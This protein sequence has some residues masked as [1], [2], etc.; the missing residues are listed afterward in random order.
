MGEMFQGAPVR[1]HD[2]ATD[3]EPKSSPGGLRRRK[4]IEHTARNLAVNP[5]AVVT[6][7]DFNLALGNAP[8]AHDNFLGVQLCECKCFKRITNEIENDLLD[9]RAI[10]RDLREVR[11]ELRSIRHSVSLRIALNE[12]RQLGDDCVDVGGSVLGILITCETSQS[13]DDVSSPDGL[14][15]DLS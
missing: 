5:G 8:C 10:Q 6:D 15:R 3:G 13:P 7:R 11:C 14:L 4:W 2:G 12:I 9:L 1:T